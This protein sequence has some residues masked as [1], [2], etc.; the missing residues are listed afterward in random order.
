MNPLFFGKVENGKLTLDSP[1]DFKWHLSGLKGAVQVTVAK[2]RKPRSL[3]ENNYYFGVIIKILSEEIGEDREILHENLKAM[4]LKVITYKSM[5]GKNYKFE[6]VKSTTELSTI[7]AETYYEE[8][9][10]W[11][12]EFLGV[13][14]P[15][16]NQVELTS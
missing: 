3:E 9:R 13:F 15:L 6:R 8:I 11:A 10:Q 1:T 12:M 2:K 14:I 5:R 4:F 16:P 7:E